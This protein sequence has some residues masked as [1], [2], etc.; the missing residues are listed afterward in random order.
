M[1]H[2]SRDWQADMPTWRGGKTPSVLPALK[3]KPVVPAMVWTDAA[4][5]R[6]WLMGVTA[7]LY[8]A[9]ELIDLIRSSL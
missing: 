7:G 4:R 9:F 6:A 3:A 2:Q 8:V 1:M 5:C